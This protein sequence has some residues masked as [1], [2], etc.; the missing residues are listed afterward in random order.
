MNSRIADEP[1]TGSQL[2]PWM[3]R[4]SEWESKWAL[5]VLETA[6]K[7]SR[8]LAIVRLIHGDHSRKLFISAALREISAAERFRRDSE[9]LKALFDSDPRL[10]L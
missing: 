1:I 9:R 2:S 10:H 7:V 5:T 6:R 4:A 3:E 8:M